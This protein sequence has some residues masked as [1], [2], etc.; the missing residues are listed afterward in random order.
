MKAFLLSV[1]KNDFNFSNQLKT[2][3]KQGFNLLRALN[4]NKAIELSC[5]NNLT[6]VGINADNINYLPQLTILRDCISIPIYVMTS[7][8]SYDECFKAV[9][10]GADVIYAV[11]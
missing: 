9:E 5:K 4:M 7:N 8:F 10:S 2:W 11:E 1:E 6:A 3:E